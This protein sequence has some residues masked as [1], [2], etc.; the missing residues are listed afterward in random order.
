MRF[1]LTFLLTV[2]GSGILF[3]V[4][5]WTAW[6][7]DL[8][9]NVYTDDDVVLY[10]EEFPPYFKVALTVCLS[11]VFGFFVAVAIWLIRCVRR[12]MH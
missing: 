5:V 10:R 1:W 8:H 9:L 7:Y 6:A 4:I 11:L 2:L 12:S 3:G